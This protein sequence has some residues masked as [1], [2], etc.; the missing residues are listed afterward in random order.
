MLRTSTLALSLLLL[1]GIASEGMIAPATAE[2]AG[3]R[4]SAGIAEVAH[5]YKK[6]KKQKHGRPKHHYNNHAASPRRHK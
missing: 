1:S 4:P 6:P 3:Q 5:R 2:R